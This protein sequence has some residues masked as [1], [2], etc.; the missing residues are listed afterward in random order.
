MPD[1]KEFKVF[2]GGWYQRTTLH[3][4]EIANFMAYGKS[5]LP[6][7]KEK[8]R[9]FHTELDLKSVSREAGYLEYVQAETRSGIEIHYYE[10]GLYILRMSSSNIEHAKAKLE[11]YYEDKFAPAIAY[12]FSLGAPTPKELANIKTVHPIAVGIV[13]REPESYVVDEA[14]YG[15]VYSSINSEE[16]M[17][18]KTVNLGSYL[19]LEI[20][21]QYWLKKGQ[22]FSIG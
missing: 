22:R 9:K 11:E 10:D 13:D 7:S 19:M 6:L 8:L 12:I 15:T 16:L 17:V 21:K 14:K 18:K 1:G 2:F 5:D 20:L 4:T 3:L